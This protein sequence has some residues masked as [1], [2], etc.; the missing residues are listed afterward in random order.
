MHLCVLRGSQNKQRL[1]LYTALTYRF[2]YNRGRECL[3]RG[4]KWIFKSDRYSFVLKGLSRT[5]TSTAGDVGK[6]SQL[7]EISVALTLFP[8][9]LLYDPPY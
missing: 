6:Q 3:L 9:S 2:F 7:F 4:T 5:S 1:F 8:V